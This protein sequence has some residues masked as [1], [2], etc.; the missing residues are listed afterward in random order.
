MG[1][2]ETM[3][4]ESYCRTTEVLH[5]AAMKSWLCMMIGARAHYT[6]PLQLMQMGAL[7]RLYTD[8]WA[9]P[10][11]RRIRVGPKLLRGF[12]GRHHPALSNHKVTAFTL[13]AI[14]RRLLRRSPRTIEEQYLR[15]IADGREFSQR[16]NH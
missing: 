7:A 14:C 12:S 1:I 6:M 8:A 13:N 9:G 4:E 3:G 2:G 10:L 5:N 11:L 16:V 15:F